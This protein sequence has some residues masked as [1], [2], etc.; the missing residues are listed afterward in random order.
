[1]AR[2]SP[3]GTG[4]TFAPTRT[5]CRSAGCRTAPPATRE[6]RR[7]LAHALG[8]LADRRSR[9]HRPV[10]E[11]ALGRSG[12]A[13]AA[14]AVDVL[15]ERVLRL[16]QHD[17]R[18]GGDER[19]PRQTREPRR[20]PAQRRGERDP[21]AP[22]ASA[23]SATRRRRRRAGS[24]PAAGRR[25]ARRTS[26][27]ARRRSRTGPARDST[28]PRSSSAASRTEVIPSPAGE[29]SRRASASVAG[30]STSGAR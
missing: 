2:P 20:R 12:P 21:A 7:A 18:H 22:S 8:E 10:R 24:G 5:R 6:E 4:L 26:R 11:R 17:D 23:A 19:K 30:S 9:G 14:G 1:M 15:R 13:L 25:R 27:P 16:D 3:G 28:A 29:T